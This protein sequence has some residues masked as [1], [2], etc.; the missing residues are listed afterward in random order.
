MSQQDLQSADLLPSSVVDCRSAMK[1]LLPR[2]RAALDV[3]PSPMPDRPGIVLR[4][5]FRYSEDTLLIPPA[6]VPLLSCLDGNHSELDAQA[7]LVRHGGGE[8][9]FSAD[10]RQFVDMLNSRGFLET[11]EFFAIQERRQAEF[12]ASAERMPALAGGA[13]PEDPGLLKE[14]FDPRFEEGVAAAEPGVRNGRCV[15][16]AAPHVSPVGA[17]IATQQL[18][19]WSTLPLQRKHL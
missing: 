15:G 6:W 18:T 1:E 7:M 14:T 12:R 4:D 2:L 19:A 10:L 3:M 5:P 16:L 13:Y 17:G 11:E 9:V 8:L